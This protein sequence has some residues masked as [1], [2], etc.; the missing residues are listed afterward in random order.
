MNLSSVD[1]ILRKYV[2]EC[3]WEGERNEG[4]KCLLEKLRK[5]CWISV[6][7]VLRK[8]WYGLDAG[9]MA[10]YILSM[11]GIR[12]RLFILPTVQ[13]TWTDIGLSVVTFAYDSDI[14]N[15]TGELHLWSNAM[16]LPVFLK[17]GLRYAEHM[18]HSPFDVCTFE[19][20]PIA[21]RGESRSKG[22]SV[23]SVWLS[24]K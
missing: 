2:V 19:V 5:K 24:E 13:R 20:E 21:I 16:S 7:Q 1:S 3:C 12:H 15:P 17:D 4:K 18:K 23:A 9:W 6:Q 11:F 14:C 8:H 10:C 22:L